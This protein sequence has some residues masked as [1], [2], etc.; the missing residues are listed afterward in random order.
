MR[1]PYRHR[2]SGC[3]ARGPLQHIPVILDDAVALAEDNLLVVGEVGSEQ[4]F[5]VLLVRRRCDFE[6]RVPR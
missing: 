6:M 2:R 5:A 3:Q 4:A 1:C